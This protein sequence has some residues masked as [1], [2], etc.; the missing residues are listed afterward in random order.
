[1]CS[2][3]LALADVVGYE[4]VADPVRKAIQ[5]LKGQALI[6][7]GKDDRRSVRLQLRHPGQMGSD[8]GENLLHHGA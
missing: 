8:V 2:S 6:A 1:M 4:A 7:F 5:L 3:D